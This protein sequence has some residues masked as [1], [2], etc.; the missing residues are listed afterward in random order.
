M[1]EFLLKYFREILLVVF[2]III[3][4]FI[5]KIYGTSNDNSELIKYKLE[6]LDKEIEDLYNQRKSLD[7]SINVHNENIKKI[8]KAINNLRIEKT[9][10]YRVYEVKE[11][12]IKNADARKVDSLLRVKYRY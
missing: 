11:N 5:L 8:D 2:A 6:V 4:F 12:E 10:I 7:S 9:T 3:I 1:K